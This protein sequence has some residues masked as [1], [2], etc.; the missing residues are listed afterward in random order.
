MP[1]TQW[2]PGAPKTPLS[3]PACLLP[4]WTSPFMEKGAQLRPIPYDE[5]PCNIS[6]CL[7]VQWGATVSFW[8]TRE[9]TFQNRYVHLPQRRVYWLLWLAAR[10]ISKAT[11]DGTRG[12]SRFPRKSRGRTD[13]S[14]GDWRLYGL[15]IPLWSDLEA[16]LNFF[17]IPNLGQIGNWL[18]WSF[19]ASSSSGLD[20]A[21]CFRLRQMKM[22]YF[23]AIMYRRFVLI[24]YFVMDEMGYFFSFFRVSNLGDDW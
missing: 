4:M 17:T 21:I 24:L 7:P 13:G 5:T 2:P 10:S 19:W 8:N 16:F 23:I 9:S 11:Q 22:I 18:C 1:A 15:L 12:V 3:R 6:P 20:Y 14:R